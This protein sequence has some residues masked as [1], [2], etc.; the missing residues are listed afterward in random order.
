[1]TIK[2]S[3][4][5]LV[6]LDPTIGTEINKTRPCLVIGDDTIGRLKSKTVLP[7]TGWNEMYDQVPW[8][9]RCEPTS[10]NGLSKT[11]AID[12]FQIRNLSTKRFIKRIGV[13]DEDLLVEVHSVVA[14]TLSVRYRLVRD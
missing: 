10:E 7:I 8:M 6:N 3:E 9:V 12:A 5:W 14:K 4:I 2:Q 13:I 11:S 1:M